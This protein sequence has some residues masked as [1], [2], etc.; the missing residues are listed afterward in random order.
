MKLKFLSRDGHAT[1]FPGVYGIGQPSVRVARTFVAA[2][3]GKPVR[4]V[5]NKEPLEIDSD[6]PEAA[7]LVRKC[8][9]GEIWAADAAT[10]SLC[11]VEFRQ[12]QQDADGEWNVAPSKTPKPNKTEL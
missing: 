1:P 10:A 4:Y 8:R 11:G 5:A 2:A 6:A 9:K 7:Y 3:D 12:L